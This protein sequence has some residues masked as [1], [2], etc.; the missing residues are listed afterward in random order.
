[1]YNTGKYVVQTLESV[2]SQNYPNVYHIIVDDCSSD[3]SIELVEGWIKQNN[4]P[5]HFIK[6]EKNKGVQNTLASI[7]HLLKGKY[8]LFLADDVWSSNSLMERVLL[9]ESLDDSYGM[10]YGDSNMIDKDGK[11]LIPSMFKFYRGDLFQ[12]PSGNIFKEVLKEFYFFIQASIIRLEYFQKM[13]YSFDKEIISEDWDWQL[14]FSMNYNILGVDKIYASYRWLETSVGRTNWT[15]EKMHNVLFSHTKMLLKYYNQPTNTAEDNEL[16]FQK[17]WNIY[18]QLL[19][20]PAF[21]KN[22]KLRY[23]FQLLKATR[24]WKLIVIICRVSLFSR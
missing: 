2:K 15:D 1:M 23:L 12:P 5:C 4:Y 7:F 19:N 18:N 11:E 24:K 10:V 14:W 3:N 9:F 21:T 17:I 13:N 6:N 22:Q 16:I 8:L 20:L